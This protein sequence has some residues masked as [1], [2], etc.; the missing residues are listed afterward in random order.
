MDE[1]GAVQT[2]TLWETNDRDV[3]LAEAVGGRKLNAGL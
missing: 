3:L 1:Y 2:H